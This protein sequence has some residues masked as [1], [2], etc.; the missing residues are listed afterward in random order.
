MNEIKKQERELEGLLA[1]EEI[2]WRQRAKADWLSAGDRNTKFFHAR[3]SARRRKNNIQGLFD[4]RGRFLDS[5]EDIVGHVCCYFSGLFRSSN[6]GRREINNAIANIGSRIG[7]SDR[8]RALNEELFVLDE[9]SLL[10]REKN[11]LR[12]GLQ[13]C[14]EE[15]LALIKQKQVGECIYSIFWS[16]DAKTLL[17]FKDKSIRLSEKV[18]VVEKLLLKVGHNVVESQTRS[19][20]HKDFPQ[21]STQ[22][23]EDLPVLTALRDK[24]KK[25]VSDVIA[26]A[27]ASG[28][29][30]NTDLKF[31]EGEQL[32][33]S[34]SS[35]VEL[36]KRYRLGKPSKQYAPWYEP[37][38]KTVRL[39]EDK[40]QGSAKSTKIKVQR[41]FSHEDISVEKA[42]CS[43]IREVYYG[44]QVLTVP[45]IGIEGK[46]DIRKKHDLPSMDSPITFEHIFFCE[47]LYG[48]DKAGA[49]KQFLLLVTLKNLDDQLPANIKL[50]LLKERVVDDA[51]K[52]KEKGTSK[53]GEL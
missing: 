53:E 37:V 41:I 31:F 19:E 15:D 32:S 17:D 45:I 38:L 29:V 50:S 47:H 6:P 14:L 52:R 23:F 26:E 51:I 9:D 42:Y 21:T 28:S 25:H 1:K 5:E 11:S 20:T 36:K 39:A 27:T 43:D 13:K 4:D 49:I 16:E 33:R 44:E 24:N 35:N 7:E 40:E 18:S 22:V 46:C 48:S 2:Y 8:A 12:G 10:V 30:M 3:A 34:G